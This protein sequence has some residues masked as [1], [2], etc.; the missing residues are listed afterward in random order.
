MADNEQIRA[1][2]K[3]LSERVGAP[4]SEIQ[5]AVDNSSYGKLL[6]KL[7]SDKA[8]QVEDILSDE[9]KAKE[10]LS[11]PQAQAIMKRFMS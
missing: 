8:K 4:E 6:S 11:T 2:I 5:N 7:P 1:L 9:Q 10:F 3:K